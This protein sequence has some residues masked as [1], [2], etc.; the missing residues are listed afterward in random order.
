MRQ[1]VVGSR[2]GKTAGKTAADPP[3]AGR[4]I[5]AA[6]S[7]FSSLSVTFAEAGGKQ[8]PSRINKLDSCLLRNDEFFEV[9]FSIR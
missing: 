6:K 8:E 3:V 2:V 5:A 1:T 4:R 7:V 9:P